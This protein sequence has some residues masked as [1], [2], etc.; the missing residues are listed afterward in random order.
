MEAGAG[1][2]P[3]ERNAEERR[4]LECKPGS[5][6]SEDDVMIWRMQVLAARAANPAGPAYIYAR[7]SIR[8]TRELPPGTL[9]PIGLRNWLGCVLVEMFNVDESKTLVQLVNAKSCIVPCSLTPL[10][11]AFFRL[12]SGADYV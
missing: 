1:T 8:P 5:G 4:L 11:A 3:P 10:S 7:K 6:A 2:K 9:K 12:L